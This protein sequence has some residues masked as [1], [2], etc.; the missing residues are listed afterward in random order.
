[1]QR[2]IEIALSVL[3]LA[4]SISLVVLGRQSI[5]STPSTDRST[6]TPVSPTTTEL[7]TVAAAGD[8]ACEPGETASATACRMGETADLV[9][10]RDVDAI[11]LLGDLQYQDGALEKFHAVF[12]QTWGKIKARLYPSPGNHE[13]GTPA[14]KGYFDYFGAEAGEDRRGYYSFNLGSWHI[15]SLNS[16]CSGAGG[17]GENSPQGLWL[18]NDLAANPS[19]CTLAFWHHPRFSSGRYHPGEATVGSFWNILYENGADVVL[20]GHD[21]LYERF[22]PM[23]PSGETDEERGIRQF[24]VGT[25]G[26]SLYQFTTVLPTSEARNDEEFGVLFLILSDGSYDW[27][28]VTIGGGLVD[29][30]TN[31]CH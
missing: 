7:V 31:S 10:S 26:R 28:F 16:N 21:H 9:A 6:T 24:T 12:D 2:S 27:E 29:S 13:Y 15:V 4:I 25:G 11:L 1:M 8:I 17:C 23:N 18:N 19:Q 14:A 5:Q 3:V 22:A 20:N 30:G